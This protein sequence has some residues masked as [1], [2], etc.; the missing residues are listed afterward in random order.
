MNLDNNS[1]N[2]SSPLY[3]H[4]SFYKHQQDQR[5]QAGFV[6]D[7]TIDK[8]KITLEKLCE[9]VSASANPFPELNPDN[10]VNYLKG[11]APLVNGPPLNA[12]S[13][14][15]SI[16]KAQEEEK[17]RQ[18]DLIRAKEEADMLGN[19]VRL[20]DYIAVESLY[21]V[22]LNAISQ[23]RTTLEAQ[24]LLTFTVT[25]G[26]KGEG[27]MFF[28]PSES[29]MHELFRR[30][31]EDVITT[32]Y[33]VDRI[34]TMRVFRPFLVKNE[35]EDQGKLVLSNVLHQDEELNR[36]R[37]Q[38][39]KFVNKDYA[40]ATLY[41]KTFEELIK[42]YIFGNNWDEQEY[43]SKKHTSVDFTADLNKVNRALFDLSRMV[44]SNEI[45]M[46]FVESKNLQKSMIPTITKILEQ[47][48]SIMLVN[49]REDA[50]KLCQEFKLRFKPLQERPGKMKEFAQFVE[51]LLTIV[52]KS[53]E[54]MLGAE[55]AMK[56]YE[57]SIS[58]KATLSTSDYVLME[59]LRDIK[60]TFLQE[61]QRAEEFKESNLLQY[62]LE[63][64]D[65][66]SKMNAELVNIISVLRTGIF[67][68][69][70]A[71]P[72]EVLVK[73]D[74]WDQ[75][76]TSL[77]GKIDVFKQYQRL[78]NAK[79][80]EWT[81]LIDVKNQHQLRGEVWKT[82]Q[83]VHDKIEI[84]ELTDIRIMD[85]P[86]LV[87]EMRELDQIVE[88]L[89]GLCKDDVTHRLRSTM[90]V[91]KERMPTIHLITNKHLKHYHWVYFA[92][93]LGV[94]TP[95]LPVNTIRELQSLQ[96]FQNRDLIATVVNSAE[97]ESH[98][99]KSLELISK[100]LKDMEFGF[101]SYGFKGM[102]ILSSVDDLVQAL[103][104][105]QR[106][107]H[108]LYQST[109][110]V[111]SQHNAGQFTMVR[112]EVEK[113]E[114]KLASIIEI[115]QEWISCQTNWISLETYFQQGKELIKDDEDL[116]A[117]VEMEFGNWMVKA[118]AIKKVLDLCQEENL[119][120]TLKRWNAVL[121][122]LD[123]KLESTGSRPTSKASTKQNLMF[124]FDQ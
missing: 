80:K 39:D 24:H 102:F 84:W 49:A 15:K 57:L 48:K 117:S 108:Q 19:F 66:V 18:K 111:N 123:N 99:L 27:V 78:F 97:S 69:A 83:M 121:E 98:L 119:L 71:N 13:K 51:T 112:G 56:L 79:T 72:E 70:K 53:N 46:L 89:H 5:H 93:Q 75:Q 28:H 20:V 86:K 37:E 106:A 116:F 124:D 114:R 10:I 50:N 26:F 63:L 8:I 77:E 91:W 109:S 113:W 1:I 54:L 4:E 36:K 16:I 100:Q 7:Q 81:N 68:M 67:V 88:R 30:N 12:N 105:N 101:K 122:Q 95:Q 31:T 120:F 55:E 62:Q 59:Q 6:F 110:Q 115:V 40:S 74:E 60:D 82:V 38:I 42:W 22:A 103:E 32:L 58:N 17:Q 44:L 33:S 35:V 64:E 65:N 2:K 3:K 9:V 52:E 92:K 43:A 11:T 21:Y 76:I 73:L 61:I 47:I 34:L 29:D 104:Q 45:G 41:S 96:I 87:Q 85:V 90:E 25:I 118:S 107:L 14:A 23:F 94:D